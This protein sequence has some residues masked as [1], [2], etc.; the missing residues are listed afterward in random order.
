[1]ATPYKVPTSQDWAIYMYMLLKNLLNY[2]LKQ[3]LCN[4]LGLE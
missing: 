4:L 2:Q 3:L 1:M